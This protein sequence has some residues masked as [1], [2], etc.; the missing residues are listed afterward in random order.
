MSS[1]EFNDAF[2]A[3]ANATPDSKAYDY[4]STNQKV[5]LYYNKL[6]FFTQQVNIDRSIVYQVAIAAMKEFTRLV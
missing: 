3:V 1:A 6:P 5:T 4:K 2:N